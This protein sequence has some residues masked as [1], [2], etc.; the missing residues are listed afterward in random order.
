MHGFVGS[1]SVILAITLFSVTMW[2][3]PPDAPKKAG[4]FANPVNPPLE[5]T[6][7]SR[8]AVTALRGSKASVGTVLF[9]PQPAGGFAAVIVKL[10]VTVAALPPNAVSQILFPALPG[11]AAEKVLAL[12]KEQITARHT[13]WPLG[14]K[15]EL[16]FSEKI[17]PQDLPATAVAVALALDSMM[18][19]YTIDPG[20]VVI[21]GLNEDGDLAPVISA[22]TRLTAALRGKASR[23]IIPEKN[24]AQAGDLMLA[25]GVTTFAS[26]HV[27][28][29]S[30]FEEVPGLAMSQLDEKIV[31][32]M[33]SFE[34]A[35]KLFTAA[36]TRADATLV[37]PKVKDHL[38]QVL[39]AAPS[40]LSARLLLGRGAGQFNLYSL[41]GSIDIVENR[42]P[43]LVR[44]VRSRTPGSI[45]GLQLDVITN[46]LNALKTLGPRL[47][48]RA[49]TWFEAILRYGEAAQEMLGN[50]ARTPR[51]TAQFL[52]SL[53]AA[54][55]TVQTEW[56]KIVA[57]R[58]NPPDRSRK[59]P[60][61]RLKR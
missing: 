15:I 24:L 45:G 21:G 4:P 25:E 30:A 46:E 58:D 40:H 43:N 2:A 26:K 1:S 48:E 44:S 16:E 5:D 6:N 20:L 38:R 7:E 28:S 23:V 50:P 34:E 33:E 47:D 8:P 10:S 11:P 37:D 9:V 29:V 35:G 31:G 41:A 57:L 59:A 32:A 12:V 61:Q 36:G 49:L 60:P 55:R 19:G 3:A 13:G 56:P 22:A 17:A 53:N 18:A 51:Q 54:A 39:I 52:Q 14:Q 27:F 42:G